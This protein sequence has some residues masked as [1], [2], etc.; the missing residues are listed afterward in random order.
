MRLKLAS[1]KSDLA[2]WQAVQVARAFEALSERPHIEFNFKASLGDQNLD[3]PLASMGSKGVFT[4]DF[5]K[6][7][8]EGQC[9][10]VVHSWKDLPVEEREGTQIAMT[11]ERADARDIFLIAQEAWENAVAK[12]KLT[13]LTSSPRRVYNLSACLHDLLPHK[14]EIEFANVR[15]NVPTRLA[16][17]KE[18]GAALLLAKAGL[19][20]L[21]QSEDA[22]FLDASTAG[23]RALVRECRFMILPLSLNPGAPAQGAL[24]IEIARER[25]P[26]ASLCARLNDEKTFQCVRDERAI[27]ESYGGGCHQ[28]IGV[29]ILLRNYGM[30]TSVRGLTDAGEVLRRWSVENPTEWTKAATR[31]QIFPLTPAGNSWFEREILDVTVD[32]KTKSAL[33]VARNE[34]FPVGFR[35]ENRQLVWTAGVSTWR[36]LAARGIWVNGSSDGLGE[37]ESTGLE[38]LIGPVSWAKLT[39]DRGHA[40]AGMDIVPTYRLTNRPDTPNLRGKTHFFWMSTTTFE[41][42]RQLFPNEIQ[43]GYNAC[44]PGSTFEF[45]RRQQGLNHPVKVF[46]GLEQFLAETFP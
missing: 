20:R 10:L 11:M 31:E 16:K 4:E 13:V 19:D 44:G 32:L 18:Q 14:L 5:Y 15:G 28:K 8:T 17:M 29:T 23:L 3:L 12:G 33:F 7:L 27:L 37:S 9:D 34:A 35:P 43:N 45:L 24:A 41:R 46:A 42:A 2:R 22:G 21:L 25:E 36:K 26:V 39:H 1:R 38:T 40:A 30:V 6:D